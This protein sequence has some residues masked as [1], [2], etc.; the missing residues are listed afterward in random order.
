MYPPSR[1][2]PGLFF[3][4]TLILIIK[5][6]LNEFYKGI[7]VEVDEEDNVVDWTAPSTI[8][9]FLEVYPTLSVDEKPYIECIQVR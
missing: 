9:W 4:L 7:S 8:Q 6:N 1:I 2:P 3:K 5:C